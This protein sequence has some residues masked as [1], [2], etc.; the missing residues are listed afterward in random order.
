MA[1]RSYYFVGGELQDIK[2]LNDNKFV[3]CSQSTHTGIGWKVA[4]VDTLGNTIWNK[5]VGGNFSKNSQPFVSITNHNEIILSGTSRIFDLQ[6]QNYNENIGVVKLDT[7]GNIIWGYDFGTEQQESTSRNI[8]S[9]DGF[10]YIV[11]RGIST[12]TNLTKMAPFVTKLDLNGNEVWSKEFLFPDDTHSINIYEDADSNLVLFSNIYYRNSPYSKTK[13]LSFCIDRNGNPI[14]AYTYGNS[15][16]EFDPSSILTGIIDANG[17]N[18]SSGIKWYGPV[19]TN[20]FGAIIIKAD[21]LGRTYCDDTLVNFSSSN[22][23]FNWT[24][25]D[26]SSTSSFTEVSTSI[27]SFQ[28]F[29]SRVEELCSG[30]TTNYTLKAPK[31]DNSKIAISIYPNPVNK[32]INITCKECSLKDNLEIYNSFGQ[33]VY[34]TNYSSTIDVSNFKSGIYYLRIINNVKEVNNFKIIK[35]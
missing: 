5:S 6:A 14:W 17:Y 1:L 9:S 7:L 27:N 12:S 25:I 24:P 13:P 28:Q 3:I 33:L 18:L 10:I 30:D 20:D 21:R 29:T 11:S 4:L 23:N 8:V 26:S 31:I 2:V 22:I 16:P 19:S 32:S 15:L 35:Q 34:K